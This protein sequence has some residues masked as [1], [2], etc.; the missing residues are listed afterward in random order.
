MFTDM[1]QPLDSRPTCH[2]C[3]RISRSDLCHTCSQ[4]RRCCG[5]H[6]YLPDNCFEAEDVN[7]S[8]VIRHSVYFLYHVIQSTKIDQYLNLEEKPKVKLEFLKK[9]C[10]VKFCSYRPTYLR[11]YVVLLQN[12]SDRRNRHTVRHAM[13]DVVVEHSLPVSTANT[14]F[15]RFFER[16]KD[17]IR[18]ILRQAVTD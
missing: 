15:E 16:S 14:T 5:C 3:G 17:A 2:N 8:Q 1:A 9:I 18:D 7:I 4:R 13:D 11:Q 10:V 12:C 6:R